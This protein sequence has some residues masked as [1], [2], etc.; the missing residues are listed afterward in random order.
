M[1]I[2]IIIIAIVIIYRQFFS[3]QIR[4]NKYEK[5]RSKDKE[6][7]AIDAYLSSLKKRLAEAEEKAEKGIESALTDIER[8][9]SQIE[10]YNNLKTKTVKDL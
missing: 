9:K 8:Y 3:A 10:K 2:V 4:A 6:D 7:E 5:S 1:P